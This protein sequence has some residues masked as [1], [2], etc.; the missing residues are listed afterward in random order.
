[1]PIL[2]CLGEII[3]NN[4]SVDIFISYS[5][6]LSAIFVLSLESSSGYCSNFR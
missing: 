3:T 5:Y 2:L 1:M 4:L 6:M